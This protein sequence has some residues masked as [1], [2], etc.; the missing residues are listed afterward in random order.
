MLIICPECGQQVSDKAGSCPHCGITINKRTKRKSNKRR[1]LPNGFGQISEIKY[2]NLKKPFRAM[3]TVGKTQEGKCICRSLEP[4][5]YFSTYNDAYAALLEYNRN[6][7][8]LNSMM[9]LEELYDKW[10]KEVHLRRSDA[11]KRGTVST[12]K[13]CST[14]YNMKV[15]DIKTRHIKGCIE[16]SFIIKNGTQQ[17]ASPI[18]QKNIKSLLNQ[19]LDYAVEYELTDRN[20]ARSF[21]LSEDIKASL[22]KESKHLSFTEQEMNV[23][24]KNINIVPYVD[25]I[26][27]QCYSGWRPQ[28]LGLIE[29]ENVDL[30]NWVFTG[31]MKTSAGTNRTVPIHSK[32][33]DIV[34][35]KYNESLKLNS[36]YL[37]NSVTSSGYKFFT[38][39]R[40]RQ[41]F[42]R[43]KDELNLNEDHRPHDGRKTFVTLAKKYNVDEYAI[44]YIVGHAIT[45]ITEKIYTDRD[46]NWLSTEIEKIK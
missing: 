32:I 8:D 36:K 10:F 19:L 29:L 13:Y 42:C 6:P 14:L 2:K 44:K 3:V 23:L 22:S 7:Y 35:R 28:E 18:M 25:A 33:R 15:C 17:Q 34:K 5:A 46:L 41:A 1:R 9:T 16:H 11:T 12:W 20:Y 24:W 39:S 26:L 40:Y 45:D 43:V 30:K 4:D 21:T 27:I 37:I 38:Y 31:G